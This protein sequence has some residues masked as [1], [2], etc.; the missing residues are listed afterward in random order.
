M[1]TMINYPQ[2]SDTG[3]PVSRHA[4]PVMVHLNDVLAFWLRE[5]N[6]AMSS[7]VL[8]LMLEYTLQNS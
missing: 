4:S 1:D 7:H 3:K 6:D 2:N 5:N 8:F